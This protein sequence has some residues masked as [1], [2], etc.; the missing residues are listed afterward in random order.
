[1]VENWL[2]QEE[3]K[4]CE[5]E[6]CNLITGPNIINLFTVMFKKKLVLV[7]CRPF[8]PNLMFTGMARS[9]PYSGAPER[10]FTQV[11]SALLINIRLGWRHARVNTP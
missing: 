9:L 8:H 4:A 11:S 2:N 3:T 6:C 1:M 10:G 5:I 7:H